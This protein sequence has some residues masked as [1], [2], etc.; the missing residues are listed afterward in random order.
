MT[1][2]NLAAYEH[3]FKA[4]QALDLMPARR[5]PR[6]SWRL[7]SRIDPQFALAHY[8]RAVLDAWHRSG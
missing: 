4:R 5:G 1:T 3:Y 2:G 6:T 8:Q 7:P